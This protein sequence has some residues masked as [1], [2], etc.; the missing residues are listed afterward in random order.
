MLKQPVEDE[1]NS[2]ADQ[3]P[4]G[5]EGRDKVL[6]IRRARR[7]ETSA[8][9]P[10]AE[11]APRSGTPAG[12][13]EHQPRQDAR[14]RRPARLVLGAAALVAAAG[15]GYL[16]WDNA[17][18]FETTD[19]AFIASRP[20][21]IAPQVPGYVAQ[22][23]VTDNQHVAKG[24]T[25]ARIDDRDYLVA[26][27]QANAKVGVA[28][29]GVKNI[30]AQIQ[31]QQAQVD[32][33]QAQ[34]DQAKAS[35]TFANQQAARYGELAHTGYG[36][37][38]NAQQYSSEQAQRQ[39]A[40]KSALAALE[41]AQRQ[42]D[43]LQAQEASARADLAQAKA[44]QDQARLNLSY[45]N[46]TA[47]EPGRVVVLTAAPGEYAQTGTNLAMF[48]PDE[49]WVTA[50][51]KENQLDQMRPGEKATLRIDAYPEREIRGTV[52]S[53]QPG[54]GTA[55]SLLP[56]ENATGNYVKIVQ[57]VPVKIIIDNPPKDVVLG[58]GMS[59]EPSVRINPQKSLYERVVGFFGGAGRK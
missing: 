38:Q 31:V 8:P 45:V 43:S 11:A 14:R 30:E 55:F 35:L 5:P 2:D 3:A 12:T 49:L 54:S 44:Q 52:A 29:A 24:Q 34:V 9:A 20:I 37:V 23:L 6:P 26:L 21:G 7:G 25:I 16:W 18:H 51:F 17:S 57:R 13:S 46:V 15:A 42:I 19:D 59:V 50:N 28:E 32:A 39:A 27:A 33:A 56:P 22:V 47:S 48:V 53:I 36:S 41:V 40:V 58:P 1:R 10:E 4:A